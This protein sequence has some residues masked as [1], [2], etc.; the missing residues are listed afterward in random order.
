MTHMAGE[1]SRCDTSLRRYCQRHARNML[2]TCCLQG[3]RIEADVPVQ[4]PLPGGTR[5]VYRWQVQYMHLSGKLYINSISFA[6]AI[7]RA[8]PHAEQSCLALLHCYSVSDLDC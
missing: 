8:K 4:I 5:A 1:H 3:H 2:S 7:L 6:L